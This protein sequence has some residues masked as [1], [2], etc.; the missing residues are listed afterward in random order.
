M[1]YIVHS[2][3]CICLSFKYVEHRA[4]I[5]F[6][7]RKGLNAT[8][9][10]KVLEDV[11]QD[12]APAYRTVAKWVTELKNPARDFE[13]APRTG[14]PLTTATDEN[15]EVVEHIVMRD[16]QISVRRVAVELGIPKTI[17]HEILSNHLGM[18]KV[19]VR[20]VPKFLTPIQRLN[21][22]ECCLELL[23]TTLV[24][25]IRSFFLMV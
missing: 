22:V 5:K 23:R 24:T 25:L 14:R 2:C 9:I 6:F 18:R 10:T 21:R 12:S 8:Q 19:Y 15:I 11:Y 4:V 3:S 7:S 1:I 16:R 13:D 17:V 20:W